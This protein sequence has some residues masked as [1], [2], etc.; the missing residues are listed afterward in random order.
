MDAVHGG[1][2]GGTWRQPGGLRGAAGRSNRTP[3]E[4]P[5]YRDV[6]LSWLRA[7]AERHDI[8]GDVWTRHG[9]NWWVRATDP[10]LKRSPR[11]HTATPKA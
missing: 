11:R 2:L 9:R 5:R 4:R 10:N 7:L 6:L 8:I 1:G 3:G